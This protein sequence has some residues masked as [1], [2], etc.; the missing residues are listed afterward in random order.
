MAALSAQPSFLGEAQGVLGKR[1]ESSWLRL[2]PLD[3]VLTPCPQ[4]EA[5]GPT[6]A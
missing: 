4:L 2:H 1:A 6:S 3:L 5:A